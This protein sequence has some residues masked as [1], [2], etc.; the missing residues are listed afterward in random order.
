MTYADIRY[1]VADRIATITIDRPEAMNA[2]TMRTYDELQEALTNAAG[3]DDVRVVV[4]TGEGRAFCA[5]DDVKELFLSERK[6]DE[7]TRRA[8]IVQQMNALHDHKPAAL[9]GILINY[10]KPTI[11][12]VNGVAVG[13]G[14]D[15]ALMCDMRIAGSAARMGEFFVRR[16]LIPEAGGLI[17]LPRLVGMGMAY[18]LILSGRMVEGEE[19][20][21]IGM[22]NRVV[23]QEELSAQTYEFAQLV[24]SQAPLAQKLAKEAMRVG[25]NWELNQFF[26][27]Q[28][29]V[30]GLCLQTADHLEGARA[31]VERREA[32]FKGY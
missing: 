30:Q 5:G 9:D 24:A 13:Y 20:A 19:L 3:D 32:D 12:M 8:R 17:V 14:C 21:Q 26:D 11:A 7:E 18:E 31:F 28:T 25:M 29:T 2:A 16:G 23:P 27:Y 15:I 6:S 10:P 22:V 4:L 1:E